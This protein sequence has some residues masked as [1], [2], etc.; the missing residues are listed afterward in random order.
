MS[1]EDDGDG[2]V[3][4]DVS[5]EAGDDPGAA[6][7]SATAAA[8]ITEA[9]ESEAGL[10]DCEADPDA[11]ED[12]IRAEA[13][14]TE[15]EPDTK[16][17]ADDDVEASEAVSELDTDEDAGVD[18]FEDVEDESW[19]WDAAVAGAGEASSTGALSTEITRAKNRAKD[20]WFILNIWQRLKK[21]RMKPNTLKHKSAHSLTLKVI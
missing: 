16:E 6:L 15:S 2:N 20:A 5:P 9:A 18:T 11:A 1:S 19:G 3:G 7:D 21:M 14:E 17:D 4:E 8:D 10:E 13:P 12:E